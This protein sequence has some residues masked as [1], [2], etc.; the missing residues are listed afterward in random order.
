[1]DY[2]KLEELRETKKVSQKE[3]AEAIDL[4]RTGYIKMVNSHTMKVETLEKVAP[5]NRTIL[6]LKRA[7]YVSLKTGL[8]NF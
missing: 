5:F 2:R 6:E 8:S 7:S 1:M 4:T 3:L